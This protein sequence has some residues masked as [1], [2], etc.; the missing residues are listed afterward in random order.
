MGVFGNTVEDGA[1]TPT[2]LAASKEIRKRNVHGQ[3]WV[4]NWSWT[5]RWTG[6]GKQ[7]LSELARDEEEQRRL[8]KWSE[9]ICER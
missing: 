7:E 3:Y 4:P 1:K 9:G 6:C 8:W 5:K 2:F